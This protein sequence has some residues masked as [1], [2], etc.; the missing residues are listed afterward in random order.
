ERI[1]LG[2]PWM[3]E[4]N[5]II[6]WRSRTLI[7]WDLQPGD[8]DKKH[9]EA[10]KKEFPEVNKTTIST[11]L[12]ARIVKDTVSLPDQY[13]RYAVVFSETDIPL[14]EH[15][16]CLD[17]EIKL[18][19]EFKPKKGS[20]YPLSPKEREEL[21]AFLE[22]NLACGKIRPSVSPQAAPVFFVAK[23]DGKKRLI[24]DYRYLNS[25]T[26]VDSYPLPDIKSLL[27]DLA[28]SSYFAK[29]DV[30]W[31]FTNI[32][33]KAGDEWKAAFVTPRG[34]FEPLVMFFRQTNAPPTFQR[35]M[36]ET[37]SQMIG[38][39]KV[40]IFMD[41][42]IVHGRS[43]EELI[44]SVGKFL[45]KCKDEDLRLKISKSTFETQEIDFLGYKVRYGQYS[46]CPVKTAAIKDWPV[47]TNLKELCSFIGFCNFYRMF[48]ANFSQIAHSLHLLT[49]K[50]QEYVWGEAQQQAFQELKTRL[51][52][53]PVL[54]LPDLSKP[55]T[56]QTDASK[57]GTG[58]V[59]LQQDAAG[60]PHPCAYLSQALVG[61]EQSYQVYDLELLAVIRAL[62][63]WRPYLISPVEATVIYTDHQNITYF[64]QPQ[65]LTARQM[66]WH[67]ILQEYPVRFV[68]IAG[69]KN[70]AP[71]LLSRM[72]HFVPSV[73]PQ[74]TLIPDSLNLKPGSFSVK[75]TKIQ[76]KTP[77][78]ST[79]DSQRPPEETPKT[80]VP[81]GKVT[82]NKK[83]IYIPAE[84]RRDALREYHD[85]RPAG[86][87]GVGAMMKKV[88][89]HL[90]WPSIHRDVRQYVRG[91]QTC[92]SAKVNTHPTAP[93]I[94]PHD[95]A[96]SPFPFKQ[97]SVDLVT[98]L[99]PARGFDSILTIVDQGLTKGAYFLPTNKTASSAE[100][101]TLYH[102]AVYPNYGIPDAVISD[103]GPQ[104]VSSFT[105]DL[106]SKSGI[107][108]KATTAYRPQSNGEAERVNQ[109]IGTYLRM[110]CAEKPDDW[111]LFLADAQFAHN[112]RIH[113]THGQT[114]F[115][116]LHGYE[117]TA[118]PSDIANPPG[119]ADDRLE[120]LVA[121]RDKAII[122]HKRAQEAMIARKPSLAYKKFEVG[123]KVWLD[124]RNLRLKT[125]R[126]LTP[127]RLGPFE[128]IEEITPVV[129]KLRLPSAW[130]IH[131]VFHAS[132]LTPQVTT[133]EYGIPPE[134]PLPELVDGESEFEVKNI[135][136]HKS[137][138]RKERKELR[139]LVQWRGYSRA[140]ST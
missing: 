79:A 117:P 53:S 52:S 21:D 55:F 138:G 135:L 113:S 99:P 121:N 102:N 92:Q 23:K 74:L 63:V 86:H 87:P 107:V 77:T 134:P 12:E 131:D 36:N 61:A 6:N 129:Y 133:P 69:K 65:D 132:L 15:R 111:S 124:A 97:V 71:D 49:K 25:H 39:R 66:H 85:A 3:A 93:P 56:I 108:M 10:L 44:A 27:D 47:P 84:L 91:C 2:M 28:S 130:R 20:I 109:E 4:H 24:Q 59:L 139:Y 90:W 54:R 122:A 7:G 110:Y 43:R 40:V 80:A 13:E 119:L 103:R 76:K 32:R 137:V 105:Q 35:Y 17:H 136:Q 34:V 68:H 114:P 14:P 72:A 9:P 118:Y 81:S 94:T 100:I 96:A 58:A 50:D 42:V 1:I 104:F 115:Y 29:F 5:P 101:V 31:G 73:T 16:G 82:K 62:K 98:D 46:P 22:E 116:L 125:T 106:Y 83:R 112:S 126:K 89:K 64:R 8:M 78:S 120:Q 18:V 37:F 127:R 38:E 67:S 41:D 30:R 140:E 11:E 51:T 128:I 45:Q 48:I 70:G 26:V 33:I 57:L 75:T 88:L 60:V 19:E 123:D 95:V